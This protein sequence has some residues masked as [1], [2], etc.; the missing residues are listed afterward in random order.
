MNS[1]QTCASVVTATAVAAVVR[2]R[3]RVE[4]ENGRGEK[5]RRCSIGERAVDEC[6][7]GGSAPDDGD[8]GAADGETERELEQYKEEAEPKPLAAVA[9]LAEEQEAY[10]EADERVVQDDVKRR[11]M[12]AVGGD[13]AQAR[14]ERASGADL[15]G[16]AAR[17]DAARG[18][19]DAARV[20]L[21]A[22]RGRLSGSHKTGML[23]ARAGPAATRRARAR[24]ATGRVAR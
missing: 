21:D 11:I 23:V 6:D 14:C 8:A 1:A 3:R 20:R 22:A 24:V 5:T 4:D 16:H 18:R 12:A 15:C 2:N 13:A 19:F 9:V 10:V 17:L 7:A